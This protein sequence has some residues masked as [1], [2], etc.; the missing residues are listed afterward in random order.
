[1][2]GCRLIRSE[3]G[4]ILIETAVIM[5]AMILTL[6]YVTDTAI[7]IKRA[8]ELQ[9]AVMAGAAFGTI[10]GHQVDTSGMTQ[11]ANYD[12]TSGGSSP[13][14]SMTSTSFYTCTPGGSQV[15]FGSSCSS[16][17]APLQ[18][19]KVTATST[20]SGLLAFPGIPTSLALQTS[21]TYRVYGNP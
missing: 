4:S 6:A 13:G 1:M 21:A 14:I 7:W 2:K 9:N 18:Y 16:G 5:S 11:W 8:I 3:S 15:S 10:P 17:S 20:I 19:V 12:A